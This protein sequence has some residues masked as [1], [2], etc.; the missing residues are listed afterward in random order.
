MLLSPWM[1]IS[2]HAIKKLLLVL[3]LTFQVNSL[4]CD[5]R[6][7]FLAHGF[8]FISRRMTN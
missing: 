8:L 2:C 7:V 6:K 4:A 3:N 5:Y 1:D